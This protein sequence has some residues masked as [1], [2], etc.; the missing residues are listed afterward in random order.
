MPTPAS[1]ARPLAGRRQHSDDYHLL[2]AR[3]SEWPDRSGG[4]H[5]QPRPSVHGRRA[6]SPR[7]LLS[8]LRHLP[9]PRTGQGPGENSIPKYGSTIG[10]QMQH[11][12]DVRRR[13]VPDHASIAAALATL[14]AEPKNNLGN[15]GLPAV[16]VFTFNGS[17]KIQQ[18]ALYLDRYALDA[19]DRAEQLDPERNN[20]PPLPPRRESL[21]PLGS[22]TTGQRVTGVRLIET[23]TMMQ[24]SASGGN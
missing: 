3:C 22:T 8:Y 21:G 1:G 5:H 7:Y 12:R 13:A 24:P 19:A 23:L 4:R 17:N 20:L 9:D 16:A 15:P 2:P 14:E 11:T 10:V 18:M 6:W